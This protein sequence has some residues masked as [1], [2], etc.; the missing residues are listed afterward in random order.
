MGREIVADMNPRSVAHIPMY[1]WMK[2]DEL[3]DFVCCRRLTW[4]CIDAEGNKTFI[5]ADKRAMI[6]KTGLNIP[7]RDMRLLDFNLAQSDSTILV[8]ENAII[9]SIE[10]ARVIIMA[11]KAIIPREGVEHNPLASQF[12]D[13][14]EDAVHDWIK[15]NKEHEDTLQAEAAPVIKKQ[16]SGKGLGTSPFGG[17]LKQH[18][19]DQEDASSGTLK[20]KYWGTMPCVAE[21]GG[22]FYI[23]VSTMQQEFNP[24]PFEL[25]VL[26]TALKDVV[27]TIGMQASDIEGLSMPALDALMKSVSPVNLERVRK[28]KTRLQRLSLRCEALR[29]ELQR[30]LQD[31]DDMDRMCLSHRRELEEEMVRAASQA[32][33]P[34]EHAD[35]YHMAPGSFRRGFSIP[36][37]AFMSGSA[38]SVSL[39]PTP[40]GGISNALS[41]EDMADADAEAHL[42]VENLLESYFM[43]I[44]AMYDK[45]VSLDEYIKD[46]E[47]YINIGK[48]SPCVWNPEFSEI[49]VCH[50]VCRIGFL[51]KQTYQN[52]NHTFCCHFCFNAF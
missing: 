10:H 6:A 3:M 36:K 2:M 40:Q 31:D 18:M 27:A 30:F 34:A 26:E 35:R 25:V 51:E 21:Q 48:V 29:D 14:L 38:S 15:H 41:Q 49:I 43:E 32:I 46:T 17:E 13:S 50:D 4:I 7:I 23:A 42:E 44:D 20:Q 5:H 12:M 11:D 47:E 33:E 19:E 24:L 39:T 22:I 52:G 8:R 45:F 9:A 16:P 1:V 37:H 28:V